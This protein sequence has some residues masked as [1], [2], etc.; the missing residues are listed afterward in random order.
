MKVLTIKDLRDLEPCYDPSKYLSEDWSGTIVDFLKI[1]EIPFE[2]R[3]W[4]VLRSDFV[5]D[6]LM[7]LFAVFCARQVQH[8]IKDRRSLA[9]IYVAESF[10][11]GN[12]NIKELNNARVEA[13]AAARYVP[14]RDAYVAAWAATCTD[15][16]YA[17]LSAAINSS[18]Y[19]QKDKLIEMIGVENEMV[20][21]KESV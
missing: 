10:A 17:A 16:R 20:R 18:I 3:L 14:N 1:D 6:K 21:E 11:N 8:L 13:H 15:A 19:A 9:A 7:R 12:S 2:D 4:A 5:S